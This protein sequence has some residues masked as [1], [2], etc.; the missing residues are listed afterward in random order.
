[1]LPYFFHCTFKTRKFLNEELHQSRKTKLVLN[2]SPTKDLNLV[3]LQTVTIILIRHGK[4][5][6]NYVICPFPLMF[7]FRRLT[8]IYGQ[9]NETDC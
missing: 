4:A 3:T 9:V 1:M 5:N 8:P 7:D 6:I 2:T